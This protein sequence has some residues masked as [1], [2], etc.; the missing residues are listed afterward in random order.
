MGDGTRKFRPANVIM[1]ARSLRSRERMAYYPIAIIAFIMF[2]VFFIFPTLYSFYFSFTNW[3]GMSS[4]YE[5]IGFK[6]FIKVF[7]DRRLSNA[8]RFTLFYTVIVMVI[9]MPLSIFMAMLLTRKLRGTNAFRFV[10]FYPAMLAMVTV[11]L[12]WSE[13][14]ARGLPAVGQALGIPWLSGN[15]LATKSGSK[16]AV[17]FVSLWQSIAIPTTLFIASL[18]SVPEDLYDAAKIDGANAFQRFRVVTLPFLIPTLSLNLIRSTRD[19]LV[20]FDYIFAITDGG[21]GR[22]TE[23]L[24]YL[25]YNMGVFEMK[26]SQACATSMVLFGIIGIFSAVIIV[27]LNKKGVDQQ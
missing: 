15:L 17:I 26:F 22:A 23:S 14:F 18:Q 3:N 27:T 12:I 4:S 10:F 24:G 9:S 19:A 25:I 5:L 16:F 11:G 1:K 21:L 2:T 13:I 6:N 8:V 20:V 7:S